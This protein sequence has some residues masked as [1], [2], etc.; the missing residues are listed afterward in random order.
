MS[1]CRH[2][3]CSFQAL[4]MEEHLSGD[5]SPLIWFFIAPQHGDK[6]IASQNLISSLFVFDLFGPCPEGRRKGDRNIYS[7]FPALWSFVS[8]FLFLF[9]FQSPTPP[10]TLFVGLVVPSLNTNTEQ[11]TRILPSD[12]LTRYPLFMSIHPSIHPTIHLSIHSTV[13]SFILWLAGA[14]AVAGP[15][16]PVPGHEDPVQCSCNP[17]TRPVCLILI[18][19]NKKRYKFVPGAQCP[20]IGIY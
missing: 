15:V 20:E 12:L 9:H 16:R 4:L 13:N 18:C 5:K 10:H 11:P 19:R 7:V 8:L 3:C 14:A 2:C 6:W 1:S 17:H